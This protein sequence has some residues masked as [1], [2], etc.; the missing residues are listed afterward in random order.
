[1]CNCETTYTVTGPDAVLQKLYGD[2][3][4]DIREAIEEAIRKN[5]V[6][7][8]DG[9]PYLHVNV[10]V[11]DVLKTTFKRMYESAGWP[12]VSFEHW[13]EVHLHL[14]DPT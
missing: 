14:P 13:G 7:E 12:T 3:I 5:D 11:D 4:K 8:E 6:R 10:D 9:T 2:K 1:M